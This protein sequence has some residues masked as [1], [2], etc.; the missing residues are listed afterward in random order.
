MTKNQFKLVSARKK[1][2][3]FR[4]LVNCAFKLLTSSSYFYQR[5]YNLTEN[6]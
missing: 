5:K 2:S 6:E 3:V 4:F 1:K